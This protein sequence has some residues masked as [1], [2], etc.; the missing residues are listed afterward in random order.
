MS[1]MTAR[2]Q[3]EDDL[4]EEKQQ[5][6]QLGI[7]ALLLVTCLPV[8]GILGY[9]LL[10][11]QLVGDRPA[12]GMLLLFLSLLVVLPVF[13]GFY[14]ATLT[15]RI[16]NEGIFFGWNFPSGSLNRIRWSEVRECKLIHNRFVGLGYRIATPYG[17]VYNVKG[18]CGLHIVKNN[19]SELLIGTCRAEALKSALIAIGAV[20]GGASA[21]GGKEEMQQNNDK[22]EAI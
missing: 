22:K 6:R 4:F 18:N 5:F 8:V 13:L 19:G 20:S 14:Y 11:G 21:A 1:I 15:T 16:N 3:W 17:T 9:Q 10:T 7:W 12:S 2:T